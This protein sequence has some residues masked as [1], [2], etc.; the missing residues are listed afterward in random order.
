MML[1][2]QSITEI[3][4]R[5]FSCRTYQERPIDAEKRRRLQ[6]YL[7]TLRAGPLGSVARFELVAATEDDRKLL[8]GLGTY[9]FIKGATG[10]IVGA[11]QPGEKNL[12]DFGYLMEQAILAATDL[13]LGTCW[14]GGSFTQSSFAKKIEKTPAEIIPAVTS[15]GYIPAGHNPDDALLRR[16]VGSMHR[17]PW[18][19]LFFRGE[20]GCP[21]TVEAAGDYAQPLEMLRR[22][23]S[24]SNKQ[25]WRVVQ[26]EGCWHFCVQRTPGYGKGTLVFGL[27]RLA[28]LQRVDIGIAMCHFEMT[29]NELGLRGK[30]EIADPGPA[31]PDAATE[32]IVTWK[33]LP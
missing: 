20:F 30:W 19:M 4:L 26:G 10:F 12:E 27:L 33:E 6:A 25:P 29:A 1:S 14:L 18:E 13:G 5:R 31:V 24:A 28:D 15:V 11:V 8:R 3:I 16:F 32:Y 7:D 23:P 17:H 2:G 9:G 21:L 22:G